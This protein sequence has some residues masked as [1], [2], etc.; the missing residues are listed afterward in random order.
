[1]AATVLRSKVLRS[2]G[3]RRGSLVQFLELTQMLLGFVAVIV[4][5]LVG[6]TKIESANDETDRKLGDQRNLKC[7]HQID[8]LAGMF[9][10]PKF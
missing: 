9:L 8:P 6:G 1:M 3:L 4:M 2:N 5:L 7:L 10:D